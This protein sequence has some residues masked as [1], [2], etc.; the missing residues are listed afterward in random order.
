VLDCYAPETVLRQRLEQR[1][2]TPGAISDGRRDILSQFRRDYEPV[3]TS[4]PGYHVRLDTTRSIA[5]CVQQ[6]LAA[7]QAGTS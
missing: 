5:C 3:Q 7:I 2:Q 1:E 4:E 6:A